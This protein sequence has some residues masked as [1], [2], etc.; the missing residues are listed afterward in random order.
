M[1]Y[2]ESRLPSP[3][4]PGIRV[5]PRAPRLRLRAWLP[6]VW[7]RVSVSEVR[8]LLSGQ[9]WSAQGAASPRGCGNTASGGHKIHSVF[10]IHNSGDPCLGLYVF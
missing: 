4:H 6:P 8:L 7:W 9:P 10:K 1:D 5:S 2:K 3:A